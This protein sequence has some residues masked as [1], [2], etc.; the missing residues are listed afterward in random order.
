MAKKKH[1]YKEVKNFVKRK[2]A[3][4]K[5]AAKNIANLTDRKNFR[6][7]VRNANFK[8]LPALER[9]YQLYTDDYINARRAWDNTAL[10]MRQ[11]AVIKRYYDLVAEG[12]IQPKFYELDN[13]EK[14]AAM[15]AELSLDEMKELADQAQRQAKVREERLNRKAR[16]L[17]ESSIASFAEGAEMLRFF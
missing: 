2:A 11:W 10:N 14:Y 6:Q 4:E 12:V 5:E 15:E 9:S 1:T 13:Y 16:K 3:F 17:T 7:A 8:T